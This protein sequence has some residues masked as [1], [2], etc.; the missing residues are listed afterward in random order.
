MS[1]KVRLASVKRTLVL[2]ENHH[3]AIMKIATQPISIRRTRL[4]VM[5][6]PVSAGIEKGEVLIQVKAVIG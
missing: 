2:H 4:A 6:D 3:A 1:R 5:Q